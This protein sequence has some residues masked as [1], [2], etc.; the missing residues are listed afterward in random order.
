MAH[1]RQ[2][3]IGQAASVSGYGLFGGADVTLEFLPA[4]EFHGL[5]FQRIDLPGAPRIPAAIELV[6]PQSRRTVLD[7]NGATVEVTEHVLAA[8]A[9]LRIDNCLIRLNAPEPP[10]GDGSARH[11][12]Q[13]LLAAGIVPQN[14]YRAN[15]PVPTGICTGYGQRAQISAAPGGGLRIAYRL[16]YDSPA[17]PRQTLV[18]DV[19]PQSFLENIASART[20]VLESEVAALR[21]Q[22]LGLRTTTDDLLVFRDDGS[23]ID[24]RLRFADECVRHKIL[25]CIGDFALAGAD[26]VGEVHALR[27]GHRHNHDFLRKL[28]AVATPSR[29][30]LEAA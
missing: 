12:V 22:G 9:G 19:T 29:G 30:Q 26:L 28:R 10:N 13:P 3:T 21:A 7:R 1:R 24:N 4:P 17:I 11:F 27:S 8:L 23:L 18:L 25:D 2:N 5:V 15:L 20:F 6:V 16:D 14:A